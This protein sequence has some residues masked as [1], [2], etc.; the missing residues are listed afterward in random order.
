MGVDER[1][2]VNPY[3]RA[4][5]REY[6]LVSGGKT[7]CGKGESGD[8]PARSRRNRASHYFVNPFLK[9]ADSEHVLHTGHNLLAVDGSVAVPAGTAAIRRPNKYDP[10][11]LHRARKRYLNN[12]FRLDPRLRRVLPWAALS[13]ALYTLLFANAQAVLDAS[14]GHWWSFMVPVS[15]A[16]VFSVAHGNFTGAFWDAVGLKPNT[17]RR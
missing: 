9:G 2:C 17:I 6:K 1:D 13:A 14:T 4:A 10:R 5:N 8:K 11:V 15:I 7:L 3:L 16:L 12:T